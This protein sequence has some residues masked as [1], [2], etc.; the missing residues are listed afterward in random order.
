M[1]LVQEWVGLGIRR[2]GDGL[3]VTQQGWRS[4][5]GNLLPSSRLSAAQSSLPKPPGR[6]QA[7]GVPALREHSAGLRFPACRGGR[8]CALRPVMER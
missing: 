4:N 2:T 1:A 7:L 6:P 8:A 5:A 3:E